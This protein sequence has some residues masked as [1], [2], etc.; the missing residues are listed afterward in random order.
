MSFYFYYQDIFSETNIPK[1]YL[2]TIIKSLTLG[3]PSQRILLKIPEF[4]DEEIKFNDEFCVNE[5][6]TSKS[7]KFDFFFFFYCS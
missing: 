5:I 1:K 2:I 3:K 4:K 7:Q 6:F